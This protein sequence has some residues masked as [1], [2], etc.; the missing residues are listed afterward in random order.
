MY[1]ISL[2]RIVKYR[3]TLQF[4]A[5]SVGFGQAETAFGAEESVEFTLSSSLARASAGK[6]L[7]SL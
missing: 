6:S 7:D 4:L 1:S 5:D 2:S 3:P